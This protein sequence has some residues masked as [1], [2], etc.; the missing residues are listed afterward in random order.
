MS[1]QLRCRA[2][3]PCIALIRKRMESTVEIFIVANKQNQRKERHGGNSSREFILPGIHPGNS[4]P[5]NSSSG[6]SSREFV[7]GNSSREFIPGN[8]SRREFIPPVIH[9]REFIP[10][11]HPGNSSPGINPGNPSS[12]S[13]LDRHS[14]LNPNPHPETI[15][16]KPKP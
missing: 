3:S 16:P 11:I 4:S 14:P 13:R 7:P 10:G 1:Q 2:A 5:R 6:N 15:T 8:S 12:G 9:P